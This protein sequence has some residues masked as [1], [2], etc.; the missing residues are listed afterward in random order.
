MSSNMVFEKFTK[1]Q[2]ATNECRGRISREIIVGIKSGKYR[3]GEITKKHANGQC[4]IKYLTDF[5]E[6]DQV[7]N[8]LD[9]L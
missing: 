1:L 5:I 6:F 4:D 9:A 7:I 2:R 3:I 8:S